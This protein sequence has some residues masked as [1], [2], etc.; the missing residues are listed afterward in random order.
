VS[1]AGQF[2]EVWIWA[3][4]TSASSVKLTIE[5]GGAT[6]PN[7]HIEFTLLAENGLYL[8]IPGL[9]MRNSQVIT[10]FAGTANVI[11]LHGFVNELG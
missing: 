11:V 4:N 5:Y 6:S 2:D 3:V 9:L 8:M 7:D 1:S 10:A